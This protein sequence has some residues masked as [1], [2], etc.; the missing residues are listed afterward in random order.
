MREI[1]RPLPFLSA[2]LISLIATPVAVASYYAYSYADRVFP[3]VRFHGRDLGGKTTEQVFAI[4]LMQNGY[5]DGAN[6]KIEVD[7][8]TRVFRPTEFGSYVDA[9]AIVK[10]AWGI[11]RSGDLLEQLQDRLRVYW[12]GVEVAPIVHI[13]PGVIGARV[14][15]IARE[16]D[17]SVVDADVEFDASNG[18][19]REVASRVGKSI[20]QPTAVRQIETAIREQQV[21]LITLPTLSIA[22]RVASASTAAQELENFVREDLVVTRPQWDAQGQPLQPLEVFRVPRE[23]LAL[24]TYLELEGGELRVG[25][26]DESLRARLEPF[27]AFITG[28]LENARFTFDAAT[29]K[30]S[31]VKPAKVS[32][33]IDVDGTLAAIEA[34]LR[35]NGSRTVQIV[36]RDVE[37]T[38]P[39]RITAAELGITQL[40][41]EATTYF[42]G[43][44]AA[45]IANVKLAA[46]RFHG[47]I[48]PP[49]EV[50]SFNHFLGSVSREDGFEEG[51]I[52]VGNRTEKGVGGGVCQVSTT[53]FQA[54]LR[55]G[56][57]ITERYPH[58]YRVSYYE[59]GMGAGYDAAVFTPVADMKFVNDTKAHL[60][61]E[62]YFDPKNVT[63]TFKFFGSSDGRVV[64]IGRPSISKVVPHGP[65]LYEPDPDNV[66]GPGQAKQIEYA[67]DGATISFTRKVTRSGETLIDETISSRYVPWRNVFRFGPGFALPAGAELAPPPATPTPAAPPAAAP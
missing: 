63:L 15:G 6:L 56:F 41:T 1:F 25:F 27:G 9:T 2:L 64:E 49:G 10:E 33:A 5:Y 67:V 40:I 48:V 58:G 32:R 43:S 38:Y 20:D 8:E 47:V 51:L 54:A 57:P 60:L 36:T 55:A 24:Y 37:P 21:G 53:A 52:I 23:E 65:D 26:H 62:T 28:T 3:G 50:F 66:L 35:S 46:S 44:S 42:R 31:V 16:F 12:Y 19:I 30:L 13:D 4:A 39:D 11:G 17:R 34:A 18:R 59:N 45:R 22:P 14:A 7:G 29:K 61:I